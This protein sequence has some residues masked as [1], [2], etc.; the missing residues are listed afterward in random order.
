MFIMEEI[1]RSYDALIYVMNNY[2]RY[3]FVLKL[4]KMV[5]LWV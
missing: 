2:E 3:V 1:V 4:G 5:S